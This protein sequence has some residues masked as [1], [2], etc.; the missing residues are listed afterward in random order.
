VLRCLAPDYRSQPF[1]GS[2]MPLSPRAYPDV[3]IDV[4]ALFAGS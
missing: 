3:L 1:A 4:G 2:G